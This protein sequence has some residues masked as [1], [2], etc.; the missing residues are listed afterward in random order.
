[1]LGDLE[2]IIFFIPALYLA[3]YLLAVAC[4]RRLLP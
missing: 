2:R 1:M 3:L 4:A